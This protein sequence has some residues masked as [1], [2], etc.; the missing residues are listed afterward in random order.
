MV[1]AGMALS[2]IRYTLTT[3]AFV[4]CL[5]PSPRAPPKDEPLLLNGPQIG[6]TFIPQ[7]LIIASA[8]LFIRSH[9]QLGRN[10]GQIESVKHTVRSLSVIL[11]SI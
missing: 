4:V 7:Q 10:L 5:P 11:A 8:T 2:R 1:M 3:S 9:M 6:T